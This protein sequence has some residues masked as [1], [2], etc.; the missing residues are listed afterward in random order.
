MTT[1]RNWNGPIN[2]VRIGNAAAALS[3]D[4]IK[5]SYQNQKESS[6]LFSFFTAATFSKSKV[7]KFNTTASGANVSGDVTDFPL[8][9]RFTDAAIVDATRSAGQDIRF[10]DRD[11]VT[12]LPYQIERWDQTNNVGEIWVKVP[13][14]DGNSAGDII[15][16][17][18]DE[19]TDNA[20]PD[21]QCATCVFATASGSAGTWHLNETGNSTADG[22]A[23]A[24]AN[25]AHAQGA[26]FSGGNEATAM[27]ARGQT[28]ASASSR[29]I[30]VKSGAESYFDITSAITVSAWI[31][32]TSWTAAWQAIVTKGEGAWRLARNA[33]NGTLN[34]HCVGL[35][36]NTNISGSTT[37]TTGG[38]TWYHVAGVYDGS[39]LRMYLNGASDATALA[40]TG[41]ISTTN[42]NV[43][44]GENE[45]ATGRYF[46]GLMDEVRVESSARSADWIKLSYE[47][48]KAS[49]FPVQPFARRFRVHPEIHLQYHQ[50]RRQRNRRRYRFPAPGAHHGI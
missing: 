17:Y 43:L 3:A 30:T 49:A 31:N 10:L 33:S 44:I 21:G 24:T 48:Q 32:V 26:N 1:G 23:D 15:T 27:I 50:D 38:S 47:T 13:R 19:V 39:N 4:F 18:Y 9:L 14:V 28:F 36:T 46:N 6:L 37:L 2:E 45:G 29:K 41:S 34:F 22:Y 7:F 11:G 5:L 8:L 12:W 42:S 20:V 35:A 25:A 40:A 16:M